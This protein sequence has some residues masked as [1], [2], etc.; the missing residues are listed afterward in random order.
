M[1]KT[2]LQAS[3]NVKDVFSYNLT[4]HLGEVL[5]IYISFPH[6]HYL[7]LFITMHV[8]DYTHPSHFFHY[9]VCHTVDLQH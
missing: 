6:P 4:E 3:S 9:C 5:E 1:E 7:S 8:P 2:F